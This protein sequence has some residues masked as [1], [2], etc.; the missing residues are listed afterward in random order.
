[1]K[2]GVAI[3]TFNRPDF[4]DTC[5]WHWNKYSD[6]NTDIIVIDDGSIKKEENENVC[7]KYPRVRLI[8]QE[9]Q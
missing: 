6:E 8:Y 5:L 4:L 3:S 7:K 1:M 9:N 2:I